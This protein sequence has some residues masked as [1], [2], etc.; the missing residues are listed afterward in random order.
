LNRLVLLT[1]VEVIILKVCVVALIWYLAYQWCSQLAAWTQPRPY[2]KKMLLTYCTLT[3]TGATTSSI[4]VLLI[5]PRN[6]NRVLINTLIMLGGT[7]VGLCCGDPTTWGDYDHGGETLRGWWFCG[8]LGAVAGYVITL[9]RASLKWNGGVVEVPGAP[10]QN[11]VAEK[12]QQEAASSPAPS[13]TE[14][15]PT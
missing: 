13:T 2:A 12:A 7:V 14:Q 10:A 1:R 4:A 9:I 11:P 6:F 5:N 8:T 3:V 15:P